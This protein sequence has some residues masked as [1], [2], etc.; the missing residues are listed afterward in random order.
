MKTSIADRKEQIKNNA[1]ATP[2]G[3]TIADARKSCKNPC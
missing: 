2:L 3:A 1:K